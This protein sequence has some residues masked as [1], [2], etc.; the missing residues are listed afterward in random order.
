ME[1]AVKST[2][3]ILQKNSRIF[4]TFRKRKG[5]PG[6]K[7]PT[8]GFYKRMKARTINKNTAAT[9]KGQTF[10]RNTLGSGPDETRSDISFW[11]LLS[12]LNCAGEKT[13][14]S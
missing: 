3:E 5:I 7:H 10:P 13:L 4:M 9:A 1:K 11:L 14:L 12:D 2:C 6:E 8:A